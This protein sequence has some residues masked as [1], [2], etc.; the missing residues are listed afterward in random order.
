MCACV[1]ACVCA[2]ALVFES[3]AS[4]LYHVAVCVSVRMSAIENSGSAIEYTLRSEVTFDIM[5]L[6]A[7]ICPAP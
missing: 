7:C 5:C 2:C 4:I 3:L 1:R 6:R